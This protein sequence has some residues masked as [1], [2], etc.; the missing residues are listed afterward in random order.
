MLKR[1]KI[2]I[3]GA[4]NVGATAA[5][6]CALKQL[7]DVV[8]VDVKDGVPQGKAL[9]LFESSPID[10]FDS[11]L[12]GTT[13]YDDAKDS[14]VVVITAG[15]PRKP[16][17]SRD[18][19]IG[20]N[21]GIVGDV[22]TKVA[23]N[24]PNAALIVVSNPLDAMVFV[25]HQRSKFPTQRIMGMAGVLDTARYKAFIAMELGVSVKDIAAFVLGGHGDDMV[26]LPRYTT[27][28]GIPLPKLLSSDKIEAIVKRTRGGGGEIT[29][30]L[31]TSAY[32]APGSAVAEMVEAIVRDR[33][34]ILPTAAFCQKEYGVGGYFVGVP[35][36]IGAG[37]V[38]RI[39]EID[40]NEEEKRA[41]AESVSHVKEL[42]AAAET[43]LKK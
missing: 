21:A 10:T 39:F 20:T 29:Q 22:A 4:G 18:D 6:L 13:N 5:H 42:V 43:A 14:D 16:G 25:A 37:G 26:P 33:K 32:Y 7:G 23:A 2:T 17:M 30:L 8:L 34:R 19:L 12:V 24:S 15:I 11:K 9:D 36:L 38:E 3:V 41:L 28:G 31:G 35:A 40:L 1:P 27:V